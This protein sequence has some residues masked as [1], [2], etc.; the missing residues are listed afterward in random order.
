[1]HLLQFHFI[2]PIKCFF[3]LSMYDFY[4]IVFYVEYNHQATKLE[5]PKNI[6]TIHKKEKDYELY[7]CS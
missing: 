7:Y 6:L 2:S 4:G 5:Y 3:F 1:M